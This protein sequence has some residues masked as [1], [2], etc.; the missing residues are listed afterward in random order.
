MNHRLL[1]VAC[2]AAVLCIATSAD[3]ARLGAPDVVPVSG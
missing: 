1:R 2:C 3:A